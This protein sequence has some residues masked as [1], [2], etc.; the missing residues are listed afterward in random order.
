MITDADLVKKFNEG[1][2]GQQWAFNQIVKKYQQKIYWLLRRMVI[3]HDDADDLLQDTFIKI[4]QGLSS[5]RG[6]AKLYT[7]IYRIA[8]NEALNFLTKRRKMLS[9]SIDDVSPELL[10]HLSHETVASGDEIQAKLQKA[11]LQ[12][13]D[14]QRLVFQM[15][16]YEDLRYEDIAT[17]TDTSVGALK[18]SY[19]LAV[20]KI[21]LFLNQD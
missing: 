19:H 17:I 11:V 3:N 15:K 18:A 21:E 16:Y 6:D 12:L 14:K 13:P 7:W 2:S 20:K 1:V 5:Y 9:V 8:S 10:E 4:W